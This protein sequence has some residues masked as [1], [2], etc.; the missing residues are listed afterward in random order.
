MLNKNVQYVE[1]E[2]RDI[3]Q[4]EGEIIIARLSEIGFEGFEED[5]HLLKAYITSV[6]FNENAINNICSGLSL[7]YHKKIINKT[8]WNQ[9]WEC[10]FQPVT[11]EGKTAGFPWLAIRAGFHEKIYNAEH[12]LIITPKMSFGTGHHPTTLLM[13]KGMREIE[14]QKR[15]VLDFGTGTAILAILAEKLGAG[16][17]LA[18]D[19]DDWCIENAA[20]NIAQNRCT[21]IKL[22]KA[23]HLDSAEK[24]DIILAN[25]NRNIIIDQLSSFRDHLTKNGT[26]LISGLLAGDESEIAEAGRKLNFY[27]GK[28]TRSGSWISLRYNN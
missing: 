25:L 23:D 3:E 1:L 13:A 20:E 27:D 12:E 24:F 7:Q 10:S 17:V 9:A 14:F 4:E 8:N 26:L 2:F 6:D 22:E 15:T 21:R 19:N 18:I 28:L 16:V 11:I 5:H